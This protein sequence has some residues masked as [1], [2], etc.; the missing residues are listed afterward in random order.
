MNR[1]RARLFLIKILISLK[2]D[3][4]RKLFRTM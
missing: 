4:G 3:D 1:A 2:I